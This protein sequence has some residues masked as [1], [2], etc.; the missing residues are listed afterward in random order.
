MLAGRRFYWISLAVSLMMGLAVGLVYA[1]LIEPVEYYDTAPVDLRP[2]LRE[3]YLALIALSYSLTGDLGRAQTR[4]ATLGG[5]GAPGEAAALADR[6]YRAAGDA[7]T[8]RA[9]AL[10]AYALGAQSEAVVALLPTAT[11]TVTPSPTVTR[12]PLPTTPPTATP[13]STSTTVPRPQA[14]PTPEVRPP[15]RVMEQHLVCDDPALAGVIQVYV[16]DAQ[17][18]GLPNI[19]IQVSWENGRNRF[20]TGLKPEIDPGYADFQ[21][22]SDQVYDIVV[23]GTQVGDLAT[24]GCPSGSAGWRLVFRRRE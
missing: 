16:Q 7:Q 18:E 4:L 10:L 15:Y 12:T 13:T 5:A 22:S 24:E 11:L 23:W 3:D 20:F 2:D 1:W 8:V 19:E 14:S 21:M 6:L 9:L 17:G